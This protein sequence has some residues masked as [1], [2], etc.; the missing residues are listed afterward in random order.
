MQ[1]LWLRRSLIC[2]LL[3]NCSIVTADNQLRNEPILPLPITHQENLQ[4]VALGDQL[5]HEVR[6]SADNSISC[7]SCHS[8]SLGGTD[9][10]PR[11][12]GVGG[13]EGVINTPTVFNSGF[14]LAQFW[15]GRASSLEEQIDGPIHNP[16]EMKTNWSQVIAKLKQDTQLVTTFDQLYADGMTADTIRRAIA[17]FERSLITMNAPFDQWLQGNPFILNNQVLSGYAAFKRYGCIACHQGR[18]VG[19]NLFQRMGAMGDYFADRGT[20]ITEA[21]LGRFNVTGDQ[22]DRHYFKVPSLRLAVLTPPYFHDGTANSLEEAIEE[23]GRYQ[24]GLK[25]SDPDIQAI[26]AF[27]HSL[28]GE[29][30][31]LAQ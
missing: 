1:A 16:V 2:W 23:M 9:R 5:F 8:L 14:Q 28:V 12:F 18:N 13:A 17:S 15:D 6:L 29:H 30:S 7:A 31:K 26:I 10:L 4:E 27:L 24:L 3:L 19:G 20:P 21:D 25:L 11:S 22:D